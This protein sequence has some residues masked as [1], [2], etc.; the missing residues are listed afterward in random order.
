MKALSTCSFLIWFFLLFSFQAF[1]QSGNIKGKV[2]SGEETLPFATIQIK[3]SEKGVTSGMDGNY[4]F[5]GLEPGSYT[6]IVSHVGHI[7][8]KK[9]V[10]VKAGETTTVNFVMTSSAVLDEI[11]VSGTMK[12][13]FVSQ[14]PK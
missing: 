2:I 12:P 4:Y 13:T 14:A 9:E 1:G 11:V 8:E 5:A 6:L 3:N 10:L 7:S